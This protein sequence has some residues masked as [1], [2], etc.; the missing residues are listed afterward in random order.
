LSGPFH[1]SDYSF[2]VY[3]YL[4][5]NL[6]TMQSKKK[7]LL[8]GSLIAGVLLASTSLNAEPARA[9]R[10]EELGSGDHVRTELLSRNASLELKCSKDSTMAKKGKDGKCG[11]GKC[12]G[13][14]KGMMKDS[15]MKG[16]DGHCSAK[17]KS[18]N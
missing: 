4:S 7:G 3:Y 12:S 8:S 5:Q 10:F 18:G 15:T 17:K 6:T 11:E 2:K 14:K 13:K 1:F 9:F 16:K